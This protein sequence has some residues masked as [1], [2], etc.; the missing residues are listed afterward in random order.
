MLRLSVTYLPM[1]VLLLLFLSIPSTFIA[2]ET[3]QI[4]VEPDWLNQ[5]LGQ[6]NLVILDAR[7]PAM[8]AK[9]HIDGAVNLPVSSTYNPNPPQTRLA[10]ENHISHLFSDA[11]IDDN[12]IVVV[13]DD[14][15]FKDA[16]RV[17]WALWV[18]GHPRAAMLSINYAGWKNQD[19][20]TSV[21]ITR[22]EPKKFISRLQPEHLVTRLHTQLAI[23]D[24]ETVLIDVR[25]AEE[26]RGE[27]SESRRYGHIPTAMSY[28]WH[29]M[30]VHENQSIRLKT[31][32]ELQELF[33]DIPMNTKV[34]AYCNKGKEA[35]LGN[36]ALNLLGYDVSLYDGGW[37]EWG[38]SLDLPVEGPDLAPAKLLIPVND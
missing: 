38:N 35:A 14:G 33:A 32:A 8:F 29:L 1:K 37:H 4:L 36:F 18:Y 34:I 12:S 20:P 31:K 28:D 7:P 26:Y 10:P 21:V 6:K 2:A 22:P 9:G 25:S 17:T 23:Q 13:Y 15:I 30:A 24:P 11:G 3:F 27:K 19:R 5:R 16:A